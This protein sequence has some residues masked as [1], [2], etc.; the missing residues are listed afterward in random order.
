MIASGGDMVERINLDGEYRLYFCAA[1]NAPA[2]PP[3]G[4]GYICAVVPGNAELDFM[5]AGFFPDLYEGS[6]I[7]LARELEKKDF[8]YIRDFELENFEKSGRYRLVFE[9]TDTIAEYFLNGEK[10]GESDN[11]LIPHSFWVDKVIKPGKNTLAVHI[12]SAVEKAREYKM[13]PYN[14]AFDGCAESLHIRKSAAAYGWDILPRA[15]SAGIWR[16]VYLEK[17]AG[18]EIIDVYISTARA[19]QKVA[20]LVVSVNA[21]IPDEYL[22]SC[23]LR[24]SGKCGESKFRSEYPLTFQSATVY[25][26]VKDPVLW[27]PAGAGKPYLYEICVSIL[28]GEKILTE[29]R[30][31]YGIRKAEIKYTEEIGKKG[32]FAVYV[33]G[34]SVRVRGVNHTPLDV[35]HSKDREKCAETVN[36]IE[37]MNCNFVRIWGGGVYESDEFYDLC[38]KKG[39]MVWQDIMLACHAYPQTK[40]FLEK[41]GTECEA[42]AK[43]LRNHPSLIVWCGSNET[44]W[45]Y[46]CTGLDPNEDKVTRGAVKDA[47]AA[48]DPYRGYLPSTPY[49][50]PEYVARQGGVFY[51]DL[52]EITLKRKPLPEEHYWWHRND[53][54]KFTEQNHKFIAEIGYSGSP[55]L[56]STDRF[57][58]KGWT[59][60]DDAAWDCH[61]YPTESDRLAGIDYLFQNVPETDTDRVLASQYYQAEAYKFIVGKSRLNTAMNGIVLWNMRDGFPIFSSSLVDY[62]GKCKP[63]YRAVKLSY[64]PVQCILDGFKIYIVND[65]GFKGKAMLDLRNGEDQTLFQQEI[66]LDGS[67]VMFLGEGQFGEGTAVFSELKIGSNTVRNGSYIYDNKIDYIRYREYAEKLYGKI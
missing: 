29:K 10:V 44:D 46:V 38:D 52:K 50:S 48:Q 5:R 2:N 7:Y 43:R 26:Y 47:L 28:S 57:L 45:A 49:F 4:E 61:S 30:F 12:R 3:E 13:C 16:S 64:E 20:V 36:A 1:K 9:G 33:N 22:G 41:M 25:P 39:I 66:F 55:S 51:L 34:K 53:F 6:N 42:I 23:T 8:W 31:S 17:V 15:V 32:D 54:K 67:M 35:F 58:P 14:V 65:A 59:F 18:P 11:A 24:I 27:F 56:A 21:D 37:E 63:A 60:A 62:Y 19:E 40:E